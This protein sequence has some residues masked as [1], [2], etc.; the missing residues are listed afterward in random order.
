MVESPFCGGV[1]VGP[2]DGEV[3]EPLQ[4]APAAAGCALLDLD[5]ADRAFGCVV[6]ERYCC[7]NKENGGSTLSVATFSKAHILFQ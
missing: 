7:R 5:W 6:G 1:E 2:D 3:D 4:G